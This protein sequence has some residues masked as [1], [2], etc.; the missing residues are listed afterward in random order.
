MDERMYLGIAR[1]LTGLVGDRG[2]A[3]LSP[4]DKRAETPI[5]TQKKGYR[6]Q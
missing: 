5:E 1:W 4:D 2:A 6:K 3:P